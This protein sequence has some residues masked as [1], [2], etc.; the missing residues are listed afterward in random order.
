MLIKHNCVAVNKLKM[1]YLL[2]IKMLYAC[3][4][5]MLLS[6]TRLLCMIRHIIQTKTRENAFHTALLILIN[7]TG[8]ELV[9]KNVT[10]LCKK[11]L[12][13]LAN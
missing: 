3:K 1:K 7:I 11:W 10:L 13:Y 9:Q 8:N 4:Y 12:P 5:I 6:N 2:G